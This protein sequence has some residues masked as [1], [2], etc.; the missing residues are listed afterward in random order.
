MKWF[1]KLMNLFLKKQTAINLFEDLRSVSAN[2]I[3]VGG[4]GSFF[5]VTNIHYA[6]IIAMILWILSNIVSNYFTE[7]K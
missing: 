4:I 1:H 7:D 6:I 5:G 2:V 3:L